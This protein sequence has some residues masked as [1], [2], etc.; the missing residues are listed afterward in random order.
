MNYYSLPL[1]FGSK[2]KKECHSTHRLYRLMT[3]LRIVVVLYIHHIQ[4]TDQWW[5]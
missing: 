3:W 1:K 4:E 5:T 2:N